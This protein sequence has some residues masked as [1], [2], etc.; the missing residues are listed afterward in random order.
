MCEK[1]VNICFCNCKNYQIIYNVWVRKWYCKNCNC[2]IN[3][4]L[5]EKICI[6][7]NKPVTN[8]SYSRN[9]KEI[10]P[11]HTIEYFITVCFNN[12]EK[13]YCGRNCAILDLEI[14]DSK[15]IGKIKESD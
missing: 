5:I 6:N 1:C 4:K 15:I 9:D 11:E 7:C 12:G 3:N 10:I 2:E 8:C 13:H 14:F